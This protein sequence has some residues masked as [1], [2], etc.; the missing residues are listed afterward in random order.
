VILLK[1]AIVYAIARADRA[2]HLTAL[3]AASVLTPAG[4][5][6]FVILPLAASVAVL[7]GEEQRFFTAVAAITMLVGPALSR[8]VEV[9]AVRAERLEGA[10]RP[11]TEEE[12]PEARGQALV[13]G[14]G[15]FGQ[16]VNQML[17][18]AGTEVT[19]IDND[20]EM[21][22][23]AARFGFKVYFGDGARLDVLRAA[24]AEEARLICVC[25]D[26]QEAAVTI[27]E[28]A[29][30]NFPLARVH[31]RAY[32]RRHALELMEHE[33]DLVVRETFESA[34]EFGHAT[35]EAM[36]LTA[37][38][39]D[40]VRDDVRRRDMQRLLIQR[41]EGI[42]AGSSLTYK[43]AVSQRVTPQPLSEPKVRSVALSAET[44]NAIDGRASP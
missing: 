11:E 20:I 2:G 35:L 3:R 9:F 38:E 43:Q 6:S 42:T 1:F 16:Q 18:S 24:G 12:F 37:D 23:A 31:V 27:T 17:L 19:V 7:S 15:R 5:F 40:A 34:L 25:V 4:E 8:A 13:I 44:Q 28:L 21:I 39:A 14:F 41:R 26:R 33:P 32:D 36:G 30:A 10:R 22:Q 29:K